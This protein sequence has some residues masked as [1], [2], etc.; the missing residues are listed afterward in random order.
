[1]HITTRRLRMSVDS[2][3]CVAQTSVLS[4]ALSTFG[5][6][7]SRCVVYCMIRQDGLLHLW[8]CCSDEL[9]LVLPYTA[10]AAD[11][12]VRWNRAPRN[13][14]N[15]L[16][17]RR[18]IHNT[19]S[20]TATPRTSQQDRV[21]RRSN[22]VLHSRTTEHALLGVVLLQQQQQCRL[23]P[24]AA[25]ASWQPRH[26]C[27]YLLPVQNDVPPPGAYYRRS[28]LERD[29][30]VCGSVS[31]K[32]YGTGFVSIAPR[33]R[34]LKALQQ[35]HLPGPG[36]YTTQSEGA[37]EGGKLTSFSNLKRV[38]CCWFEMRRAAQFTMQLRRRPVNW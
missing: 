37:P 25:H 4:A 32:G 27:A 19:T 9:P 11:D 15:G 35:A 1:M 12:G 17:N 22:S 28:T 5:R 14:A 6:F 26:L 16:S 10:V 20:Y 31:A 38:R 30:R 29:G 33:F 24:Y 2:S 7:G 23:V 21:S 13:T 8:L 34:D 36:S 18:H 3:P